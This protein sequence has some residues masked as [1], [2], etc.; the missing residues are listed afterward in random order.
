MNFEIFQTMF[1]HQSVA[2]A[3]ISSSESSD[4]IGV[5]LRMHLVT[6][7]FLEAFI[8]AAV[9]NADMFSTEP[10][11]KVVL[12]LNYQSKL[13]MALKLGLPLPAYKAMERL[14]TMRNKLAH[15]IDNEL[16][17]ESVLESL[18]THA[19]SIQCD[20]GHRLSEESA[21]FFNADG[22]SRGV[23]KLSD[24]STPNRI[25]LMIIISALIRRATKIS[26]GVL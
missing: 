13:G 4:D 15:R 6:E 23:H 17:D 26:F 3:L 8:C 1:G 25:K 10:A 16:I 2:N 22:S 11:D 19:K 12:R 21:E 14:N 7:S 18:S 20:E 5:V 9:N 24:P